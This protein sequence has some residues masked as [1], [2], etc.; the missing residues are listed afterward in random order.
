MMNFLCIYW[1]NCFK[2]LNI[3]QNRKNIE[4]KIRKKKLPSKLSMKCD[5]MNDTQTWAHMRNVCECS[6]CSHCPIYQENWGL[7]VIIYKRRLRFTLVHQ[8]GTVKRKMG[9]NEIIGIWIKRKSHPIAISI[10][11]F[12]KIYLMVHWHHILITSHR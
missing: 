6:F 10:S 5:T 7:G 8:S 1:I 2:I 4:I 12:V 3:Q 9:K 11:K